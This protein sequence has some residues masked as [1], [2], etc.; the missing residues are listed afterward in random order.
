MQGA[1][2]AAGVLEEVEGMEGEEG[3]A[4]G[5]RA[6]AEVPATVNQLQPSTAPGFLGGG[7]VGAGEVQLVQVTLE[8]KDLWKQFSKITN[9]MI[10]TKAGR[11][12]VS[13][14]EF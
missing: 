14:L 11:Y 13:M 5:V 12:D 1:T 4:A 7:Q 3:V 8:N 6:S 10:V 2:P 9:E